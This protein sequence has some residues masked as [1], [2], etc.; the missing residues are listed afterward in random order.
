M[1]NFLLVARH[2][3]LKKVS[4]KGF[5]LASLS[6][7]VLILVVMVVIILITVKFTQ[8]KPLG[9]VDRA[10][11]V[12]PE[13]WT[14]D[15]NE[16]HT[17]IIG[18]PDEAAARSALES[19][20][21]QAYYV[22][23][24]DY[25]DK[26]QLDAY[27][28]KD[29]PGPMQTSDFNDL[30]HASL[31]ANAP[32]DVRPRLVYTPSLT[33]RSVD[34]KKSINAGD[35]LGTLMPFVA[36]MILIIAN[37]TSAGSLLQ[38]VADEKENR[39]IE[40]LLTSLTPEQLIGGKALGLMGVMLTQIA[41]WFGAAAVGGLTGGYFVPALR[42]LQIPWEF[43]GLVLL[44]FLPTFAIVA[45]IMT[46]IG[47]AVTDV[48]QGQQIAG[49]LNIA[50]MVPLMLSA[51]ILFDPNGPL[52]VFMSLFPITSFATIT[53]RWGFT[54]IPTWQLITGWIL[55]AI[56][57]IA[58]VWASARIFRMGMLRY[59]TALDLRSAL[60]SLRLTNKGSQ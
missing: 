37:M 15:P 54:V 13:A 59:G 29:S 46:A 5:W 52:V 53:L 28:L 22:I 39:T 9:Y 36:G 12:K 42:S 49:V 16:R 32:A 57:G 50:F 26:H 41:L 7:P 56:T 43:L 6:F 21:I 8:T 47:G 27:Y 31:A 2:E 30:L 33:T 45:G 60:S 3:Y 18:Y 24:A 38:V 1:H 19:K 55:A 11:I 35:I 51:V 44:F 34:G 17:T 20:A 14:P 4:R 23:P 48:S 40:I 10:G 58:S 25:L